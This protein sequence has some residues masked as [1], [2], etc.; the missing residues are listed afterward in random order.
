MSTDFKDDLYLFFQRSMKYLAD[1][2][3]D[4]IFFL[5]LSREIPYSILPSK[6]LL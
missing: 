3:L 6:W 2:V 5:D 1:Q 4:H